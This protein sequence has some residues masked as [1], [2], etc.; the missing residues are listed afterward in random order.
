[1]QKISICANKKHRKELLETLQSLG[2][3]EIDTAGI[4]DEGLSKSDTQAQRAQFEKNAEMFDQAIRILD[5]YAPEKKGGISMF[6]GKEVIEKAELKKVVK[7]QQQYVKS[8]SKVL[9]TE[10]DIQE[11][12][13]GIQKEQ[14]RIEGL[15]PWMDLDIPMNFK[16]T[17]KTAV[18]IGTM[19]GSGT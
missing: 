16:G 11:E 17:R 7:N 6:A 9:R 19:P 10:K 12:R 18:M 1:M 13:S 2:C 15:Q 5:S 8:A 4:D 3:M 14:A